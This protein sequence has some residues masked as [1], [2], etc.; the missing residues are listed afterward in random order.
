MWISPLQHHPT[1]QI[2]TTISS[3]IN[4]QL[5]EFSYGERECEEMGLKKTNEETYEKERNMNRH[6]FR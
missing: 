6:V 1:G 2:L 5:K 4:P 3:Y